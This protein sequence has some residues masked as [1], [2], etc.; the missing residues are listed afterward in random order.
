MSSFAVCFLLVRRTGS[1]SLTRCERECEL[2]HQESNGTLVRFWMGRSEVCA[3][4]AAGGFRATATYAHGVTADIPA[5]TARAGRTGLRVAQE[6][7]MGLA[8]AAG[9]RRITT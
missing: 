9:D 6:I 2:A 4:H 5:S 3:E 8:Q 7:R 1:A